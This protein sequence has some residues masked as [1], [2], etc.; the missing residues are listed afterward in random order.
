MGHVIR[1]GWR[2]MPR[3]MRRM[4]YATVL[5]LVATRTHQTLMFEETYGAER[6]LRRLR[7]LRDLWRKLHDRMDAAR[8]RFMAARGQA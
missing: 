4:A 1:E 6:M 5:D 3:M 8:E 7:R 2:R